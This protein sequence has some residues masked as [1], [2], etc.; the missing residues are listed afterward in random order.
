MCISTTIARRI[1][2]VTDKAMTVKTAP[3][4]PIKAV[5]PSVVLLAIKLSTAYF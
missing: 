3:Y 5:K 2:K 1:N 4:A